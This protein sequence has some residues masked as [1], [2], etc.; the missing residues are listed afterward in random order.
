AG[1]YDLGRRGVWALAAVARLESDFGRGMSRRELRR[2]GP[3]NIDPAIWGEFGVDGDGDG[4]IRRQSP[5]DSAATLAR[6]IW[7]IGDLRQGIF[8]HNQAAWYVEAVY[9]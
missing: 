7:S 2:H 3:L 8:N 6:S 5:G 9:A 1:R 4:R